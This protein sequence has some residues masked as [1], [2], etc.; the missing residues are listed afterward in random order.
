MF[1][2]VDHVPT[3]LPFTPSRYLGFSDEGVKAF[4]VC[5]FF[6]LRCYFLGWSSDYVMDHIPFLDQYEYLFLILVCLFS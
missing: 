1:N 5:L 2:N 4:V 3:Y 6:F